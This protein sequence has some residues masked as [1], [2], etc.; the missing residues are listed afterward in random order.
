[1]TK[2]LAG[3]LGAMVASALVVVVGA[4]VAAPESG[5]A[6]TSPSAALS[7]EPASTPGAVSPPVGSAGLSESAAVEAARHFLPEAETAAERWATQSGTFV[8][9]FESLAHRPAHVQQPPI[10]D[11]ATDRLVWGVQFRTTLEICGPAGGA[12]E[13]HEGLRTI[14]VDYHSGEWLRTSTFAPSPGEPLRQPAG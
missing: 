6:T 11:I 5:S 4:C 7:A 2:S 8:D 13:T 14:F 1:M 3:L 10:D 9:V 12:C